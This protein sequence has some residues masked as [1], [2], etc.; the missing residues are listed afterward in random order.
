MHHLWRCVFLSLFF[1]IQFK[2]LPHSLQ[3]FGH[4]AVRLITECLCNFLSCAGVFFSS[5]AGMFPVKSCVS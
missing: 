5:K 4:G 1:Y 3:A 2:L